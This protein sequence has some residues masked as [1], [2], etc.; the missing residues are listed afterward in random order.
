MASVTLEGLPAELIE[1]IVSCL[2]FQDI[3]A[4]RLTTRTVSFKSTNATFRTYFSSKKLQITP[5]SLEQFVRVTQPGQLGLWLQQLTLYD[6]LDQTIGQTRT[7]DPDDTL[8]LSQLLAQGME[9]IRDRAPHG[10]RLSISLQIQG[11]DPAGL[12]YADREATTKL[13]HVV[14][15]ALG[16]TGLPIQSLDLFA[17]AYD[18]HHGS[19]CSLGFS[20]ITTALSRG[21][22]GLS[23]SLRQC[24]KLCLSMGHCLRG[25][26]FD[27]ETRLPL[28]YDEARQNTRSL[29]DLLN[30]CPTL[31]EL[32]L[33]WEYDDVEETSAVVEE[34]LFFNRIAEVCEFL[35]LKKCT[36]KRIRASET[37]VLSFFRKIPGLVYLSIDGMDLYG[38][39]RFDCLLELLSTA[40]P[41]L[42]SLRLR[43]LIS[44]LGT[45][46]FPEEPRKNWW[47]EKSHP[48][49]GIMRRGPDA[50]RP[51][52][53][54]IG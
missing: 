14:M 8:Q 42:D 21:T 5:A 24:K 27:T 30:L 17:D 31:E 19:W 22:A 54:R 6:F 10:G 49:Y 11:S 20:E 4:L 44:E 46:E 47:K 25:F 45:V 48:F 15:S 33:V 41:Q 37:G 51:V 16:S 29:C 43:G 36:L 52:V 35:I 3:C 1:A 32:H 39:G 23:T 28:T 13:F 9:N 12:L 26:D 7:E 2:D 38:E 50:R 53:G 18:H 40:M 34:L